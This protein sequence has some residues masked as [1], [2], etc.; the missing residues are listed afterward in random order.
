MELQAKAQADWFQRAG[1]QLLGYRNWFRGQKHSITAYEPP[2]TIRANSPTITDAIIIPAALPE[3]T[4]KAYETATCPCVRAVVTVMIFIM[5][6]T[7]AQVEVNAWATTTVVIVMLGKRWRSQ[8]KEGSNKV[9]HH[10]SLW[11]L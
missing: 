8:N 9:F 7:W 11:L 2:A 5:T 10:V 4:A 1:T 6:A 3:V